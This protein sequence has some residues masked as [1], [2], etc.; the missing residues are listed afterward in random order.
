[1][2]RHVPTLAG[3][4]SDDHDT[5]LPPPGTNQTLTCVAIT[6]HFIVTGSKQVCGSW[7]PAGWQAT[8]SRSCE[9]TAIGVIGN[10]LI[11]MRPCCSA[12]VSPH[13]ASTTCLLTVS[14]PIISQSFTVTCCYQLPDCSIPFTLPQGALSYYLAT[15]VSPVNEFRHDEG[16]IT[17]LWPQPE[18]SR[19]VF[20]DE[21]GAISLFNP[22]NDQV[23]KSNDFQ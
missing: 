2:A 21:T 10:F 3:R 19:L 18:G 8:L 7:C 20:E 4:H 15:D 16:G 5:V 1:M 17:R 12:P 22:V 11:P 6:P 23:C 9:A 13:L 14:Q